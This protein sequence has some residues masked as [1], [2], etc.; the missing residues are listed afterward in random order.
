MKHEKKSFWDVVS[1]KVKSKPDKNTSIAINKLKKYLTIESNVLDFACGNG[2]VSFQINNEVMQITGIDTSKNMILC[3]NA[4]ANE[5]NI[6]NLNFFELD[7][8]D[9]SLNNSNFD[10][11]LA[12]NVLPYIEDLDT[13]FNRINNILK[14]NG[15]FISSSACLGNKK[16]FLSKLVWFVSKVGII[17]KFNFLK[18]DDLKNKILKSGFELVESEQI[19]DSDEYLIV[20]K[21]IS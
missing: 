18:N 19:S 20:M 11:I 13:L 6:S 12:F 16:S 10:I 3:A 4:Y 17:P 7:I 1:S 15:L 21:K 9:D 5:N 2:I 14:T 8:F